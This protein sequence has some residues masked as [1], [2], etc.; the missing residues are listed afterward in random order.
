MRCWRKGFCV[1]FFLKSYFHFTKSFLELGAPF[2][3]NQFA[4]SSMGNFLSSDK[5][6]V[7]KLMVDL[8]VGFFFLPSFSRMIIIIIIIVINIAL[9]LLVFVLLILPL[10]PLLIV[11]LII[12][13]LIVNN[14]NL[15]LFLCL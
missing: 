9:N 6:A 10:L 2:G 12:A 13:I 5:E 11:I 14:I 15:F 1:S 8:M 4:N 7:E 3:T